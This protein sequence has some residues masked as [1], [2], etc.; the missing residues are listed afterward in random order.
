VFNAQPKKMRRR[1]EI[2]EDKTTRMR[3]RNNM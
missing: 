2:G 1:E 3:K